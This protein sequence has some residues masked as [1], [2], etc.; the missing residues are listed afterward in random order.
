MTQALSVGGCAYV[1]NLVPDAEG[2]S[3]DLSTTKGWSAQIDGNLDGGCVV[4]EAS[5]SGGVFYE[6]DAISTVGLHKVDDD[7]RHYRTTLKGAGKN[8]RVVITIYT[9]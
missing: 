1:W 3:V 6:L 8:G 2:E 4:F 5:N 7:F 9:Y